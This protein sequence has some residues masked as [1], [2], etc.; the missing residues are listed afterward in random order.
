MQDDFA[1]PNNTD[2]VV[3]EGI[4]AFASMLAPSGKSPPAVPEATTMTY[5]ATT[6][7]SVPHEQ[8]GDAQTNGK[9][10]GK[11]K[12]KGKAR[13]MK[14]QQPSASSSSK[15]GKWADKCMYAELLEMN[16]SY[17]SIEFDGI[18]SDIESGWVAVTPVPV[19]KRCL[20]IT[21]AASGI[22]GIGV[23]IGFLRV[24][25]RADVDVPSRSSEYNIEVTSARES[26]DEALPVATSS[27]YSA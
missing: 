5:P 14:S 9:K 17:G 18:P 27:T 7:E 6:S 20:A 16:E 10:R 21:H 3:R 22:A 19:G 24:S 12:R 13:A 23:C 26:P 2:I 15:P 1:S 8:A 25:F 4:S 11:N